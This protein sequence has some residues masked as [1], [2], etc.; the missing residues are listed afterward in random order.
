MTETNPPRRSIPRSIG[1]VLAGFLATAI[2][3]IATD[4]AMHG[5]GIF[6]PEGQPMSNGLFVLATVYRTIYTI[7]GGYITARVAPNRPMTHAWVLAVIGVLAAIAGTVATWD[8]GPE[9][10]PKW[11]PIALVV[12][13]IPS[14]LLGSAP[15]LNWEEKSHWLRDLGLSR[16]GL[17]G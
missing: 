16:D 17:S 5:T 15:R 13:A 3:S 7:A 10:G 14:V 2:L 8:K 4:L 11:Y 1:A 12:L 9:F 6:P